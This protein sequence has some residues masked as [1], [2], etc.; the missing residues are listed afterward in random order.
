M[1]GGADPVWTAVA[2]SIALIIV[3]LL[4][5]WAIFERQEL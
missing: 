4:A 2:G 5:A 3:F 1:H